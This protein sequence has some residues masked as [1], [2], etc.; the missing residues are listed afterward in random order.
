MQ[1]FCRIRT[2]VAEET[3]RAHETE[4]AVTY[5]YLGTGL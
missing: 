3:P 2:A 4:V 5:D 1:V